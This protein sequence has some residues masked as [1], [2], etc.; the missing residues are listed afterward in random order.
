[1]LELKPLNLT[2]TL[3]QKVLTG[4]VKSL[5]KKCTNPRE[6]STLKGGIKKLSFAE[7]EICFPHPPVLFSCT[8]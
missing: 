3:S 7:V 6:I 1:M 8:S 5:I 2:L 4:C